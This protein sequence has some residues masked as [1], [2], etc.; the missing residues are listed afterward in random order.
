MKHPAKAKNPPQQPTVPQRKQTQV[1]LEWSGPLPPPAALE[2]FDRIIPGG[3]DRI[4]RM[5]EQEQSHRLA[6]EQ[7]STDA[8]IKSHW[9]GQWLGAAIGVTAILAAVI[10]SYFGGPSLVG[11]ALVGVPVLGVAQALIRGRK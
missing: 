11:V 1:S 2:H 10:N 7:M 9:R 3:G 5:V 6:I 8:N 4:L